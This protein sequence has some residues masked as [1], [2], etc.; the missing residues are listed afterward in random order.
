MV[1]KLHAPA[2]Q[3]L[4]AAAAPAPWP[5]LVKAAWLGV[6]FLFLCGS[7]V[8]RRTGR[9]RLPAFKRGAPSRRV[10]TDALKQAHLA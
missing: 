9:V 8:K 7:G 3:E 5:R 6:G 4:A 2:N 1:A 10:L